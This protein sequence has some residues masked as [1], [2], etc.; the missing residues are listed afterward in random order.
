MLEYKDTEHFLSSY[1]LHNVICF[2]A[3][4]GRV[5]NTDHGDGTMDGPIN[6]ARYIYSKYLLQAVNLILESQ[7]NLENPFN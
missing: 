7:Q 4:V 6:E 2:S 5:R 3:P 1:C